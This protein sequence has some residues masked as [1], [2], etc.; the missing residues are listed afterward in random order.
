MD[1]EHRRWTRFLYDVD[2]TDPSLYDLVLNLEQMTLV[3]ACDAICLL[4]ERGCFQT[5]PETQADLD[6]L[7]LAS[8]VKA[9]LAMNPDTSDLQ[10]EVAARAGS[11][12]LKGAVDTPDQ[13]RKIRRFVE[14]IPGVRNAA[15]EELQLVTRI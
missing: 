8:S 9:N 11:I 1:E 13:A 2:L 15:L 14:S 4:A 5:T 6:N 7:A 3:E 10:F 12:S